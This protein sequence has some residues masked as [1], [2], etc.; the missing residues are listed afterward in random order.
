VTNLPEGTREPDLYNLLAPFGIVNRV[1]LS[2]GSRSGV[3]ELDQVEDAEEAIGWLDGEV[4]GGC[5]LRAEWAVPFD[6][7]PPPICARCLRDSETWIRVTNLS[8]RTREQDLYN[9]ACPFGIINS[10]S[11]CRG[12]GWIAQAGRHCRV[13]SE[14]SC[15][16]GG[17]V[18]QW[19]CLR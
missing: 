9:L 15:R 7:R 3:V 17:Q 16:G 2:P 8:L 1:S 10:T 6:P 12:R 14:R 19:A 13:R 4:H 11:L 5:V 18:A